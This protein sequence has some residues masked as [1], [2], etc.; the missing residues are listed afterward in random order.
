LLVALNKN[1][2]LKR[3]ELSPDDEARLAA[4]EKDGVPV[5]EMST[6]TEQGVSE[7]K[8]EA[9]ER[10]LTYRVEM[11][12]KGKKVGDIL[13]RLHVAMPKPR[14]SKPRPPCIPEAAILK[15]QKQGM[16]VDEDE[17]VEQEAKRKKLEKDLE[18][19]LGDDYYLDL[20]KWYD[21]PAEYRWDNIPEIL[22]GKNIAD[23]IDPEIEKKFAALLMEEQM[24]EKAGF[25][26]DE[27]SEE[28]ENMKFIRETAKK[29]RV[30]KKL[31]ANEARVKKSSTK[32]KMPRTGKLRDRSVSRLRAEMAELGVNLPA[33]GGAAGRKRKRGPDDEME[34]DEERGRS[35]T[36]YL[37]EPNYER[38]SRSRSRPPV[39][40]ARTGSTSRA[41][42][43]SVSRDRAGLKDEKQIAKV[44]KI[45]KKAQVK[46]GRQARKGEGD[47]VILDMKP[48]HLFSGKRKMG[49][50]DRR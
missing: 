14:D 4:L 20:K 13:N 27:E 35:R 42:S 47:R 33:P 6:V 31:L 28:D 11:K 32:A 8:T 25:Y 22:N 21:L 49:K 2:V 37:S 40:L 41:R 26:D 29:I 48:K 39:K 38:A 45:A 36:R 9:C 19:E 7:V 50:T 24:R 12:L 1:D 3:S 17:G 46:M 43:T 5:M 34:V 23:F 10:L 18:L 44:K 15:R 16:E 30:K